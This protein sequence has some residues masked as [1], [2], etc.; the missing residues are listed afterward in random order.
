MDAASLLKTECKYFL[1]NLNLNFS[2]SEVGHLITTFRW[3]SDF[4]ERILSSAVAR[5]LTRHRKDNMEFVERTLLVK[6]FVLLSMWVGG[7]P[8]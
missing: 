1:I 8:S 2:K 4:S 3:H 5:L 7:R 6:W